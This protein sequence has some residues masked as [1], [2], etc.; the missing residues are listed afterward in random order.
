MPEQRC[1]I[2]QLNLKSNIRTPKGYYIIKKAERALLNER[3][4]S[5]NNT[6]KFPEY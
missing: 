2:I 5:I 6:I 3:I 1:Y 4:R